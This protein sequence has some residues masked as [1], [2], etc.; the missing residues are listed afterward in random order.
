MSGDR[1]TP[2]AVQRH[3]HSVDRIAAR[4]RL[5]SLHLGKP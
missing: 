1:L 2:A 5:S 3:Y 4:S